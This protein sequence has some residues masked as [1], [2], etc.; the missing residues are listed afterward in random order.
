MKREK[1]IGLVLIA[2][3]LLSLC[4][5]SSDDKNVIKAAD[6]YAKALIAFDSDNITELMEDGDEAEEIL[7]ELE[8]VR[9]SSEYMER[10][11]AAILDSMTY[12]VDSKSVSSSKK[13]KSATADVIFTIADYEGIYN[14]VLDDGGNIEDYIEAL[15]DNNGEHTSEIKI[16]VI[17]TLKE[18]KW[19]VKDNNAKNIKKVFEFME[20]IPYYNW[21]NFKAVGEDEF[22][23]ALCSVLGIG[24]DEISVTEGADY[25]KEISYASDDLF[26]YLTIYDDPADAAG[27]FEMM[28]DY[29]ESGNDGT[30]KCY[31]DEEDG[32]GY[33]LFDGNTDLGDANYGG[34]YLYGGMYLRDN[35]LVRVMTSDTQPRDGN[36]EDQNT[37]DAFFNEI[38]Y[39][40][41]Y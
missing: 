41:P 6:E 38:G 32:Y 31:Y 9:I 20:E 39:P 4:G 2:S 5:C 40:L 37:L 11:T 28:Y 34:V 1:I 22:K 30:S 23:D 29:W 12:E 10:I 14:D 21:F 27:E 26:F 24:D 36:S 8:E 17:F 13:D 16:S 33:I 19:V 15:E 25:S 18:G 35:T 3:L 7:A